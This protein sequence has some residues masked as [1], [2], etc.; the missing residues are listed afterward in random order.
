MNTRYDILRLEQEFK[1]CQ[2]ALIAIGDETIRTL[3]ND[4]WVY[5]WF[6]WR[7]RRHDD[8]VD[9]GYSIGI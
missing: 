4:N 5:L 3:R 1:N 7:R 2:K 6:R 9:F 8:V